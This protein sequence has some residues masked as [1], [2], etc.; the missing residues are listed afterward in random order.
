MQYKML[1]TEI[2][3][4]VVGKIGNNG[5]KTTFEGHPEHFAFVATINGQE[6]GRITVAGAVVDEWLTITDTTGVAPSRELFLNMMNMATLL[7]IT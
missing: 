4:N 6:A 5:L 3:F 7:S 1:A 2:S